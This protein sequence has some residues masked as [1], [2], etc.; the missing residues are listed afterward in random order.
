MRSYWL[1][2][3][4]TAL[5]FAIPSLAQQTDAFVDQVHALK[6]LKTQIVILSHKADLTEAEQQDLANLKAKEAEIRAALGMPASQKPTLMTTPH[7]KADIKS[8]CAKDGTCKDRKMRRHGRRHH[9]H[10]NRCECK[11]KDCGKQCG[12][13]NCPCG[14]KG[15]PAKCVCKD[16]KS[17]EGKCPAMDGCKDKG[18]YHRYK[19]GCCKKGRCAGKCP[20]MKSACKEQ[21][22]IC[23][24]CGKV[25]CP[26]GC[27]GD[28]AKCVCGAKANESKKECS[29]CGK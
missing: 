2:V 11:G 4:V 13:A 23:S 29:P 21:K 18:N 16:M 3:L 9:R 28:P 24:A 15:D 17:G 25:D 22:N 1:S 5:L 20:A 7:Q 27:Y 14:C 26:C 10:G 19:K 12:K 8:P 6:E